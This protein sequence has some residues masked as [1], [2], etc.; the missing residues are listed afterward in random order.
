MSM[1]PDCIEETDFGSSFLLELKN[2]VIFLK[3]LVMW[4]LKLKK[5]CGECNISEQ[6]SLLMGNYLL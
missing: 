2:I 5:E 3:S 6:W 4:V 1:W